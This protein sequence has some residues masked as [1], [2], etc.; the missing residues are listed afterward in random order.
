MDV[1][2]GWPTDPGEGSHIILEFVVG[3]NTT[4]QN[5]FVRSRLPPLM[6][7]VSGHL[8]S[9]VG[10]LTN[11]TPSVYQIPLKNSHK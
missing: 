1:N 3:I 4:S 7:I 9:N 6:N 11:T 2:G 10:L 8:S 5:W